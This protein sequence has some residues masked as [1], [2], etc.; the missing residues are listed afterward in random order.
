MAKAML[1]LRRRTLG[2]LGEGC[3]LCLECTPDGQDRIALQRQPKNGMMLR[4]HQQPTLLLSVGENTFIDILK[5]VG[6]LYGSLWRGILWV[7][8]SIAWR[9]RGFLVLPARRS[10]NEF[11]YHVKHSFASFGADHTS[12]HITCCCD[13]PIK[14]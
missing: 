5:C 13:F 14:W 12:D 7:I 8:T 10:E 1:P 4:M 3:E 9:W 2:Q 6:T 11:M